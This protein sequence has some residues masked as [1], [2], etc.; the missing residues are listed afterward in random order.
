MKTILFYS[1]VSSKQLFQT[2]KFYSIDI[3]I[4]K[5]LGS[6]IILSN[7]I[8]DAFFFWKYD[9][10][11]A[12][13]Y[14]KSFFLALIAALFR[15]NTYFTGGIDDLD[16]DYASKKRYIIQ[17][18]FFRLC[19]WI[20]KSCI[21]VSEADRKNVSKILN[22]KEKLSYSEHTIDVKEFINTEILV[23]D[24][25][26][27]S[28]VWMG[29]EDNVK[30]KGIDTALKVFSLLQKTEEY[31]D[32]K[33]IIIGRKGQGTAYVESLIEKLGLKSTVILT[34]EISEAAKVAL[35]KKSKYY[36]Q[37][38]VYEGFGLAALEAIAAKNIVIHSGKGGLSNS[39]FSSGIYFNIENNL[40]AETNCLVKKMSGYDKK[41]LD[42]VVSYIDQYYDNNRRKE[43]FHRIITELTK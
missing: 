19:Y 38:S 11:F 27:T 15:K 12:Y 8:A 30:R 14:R 7:R 31:A 18:I 35:L 17:K 4:L 26:F 32:Y 28:I 40:Y 25:I 5:E 22:Q 23:K 39:I 37:L 10:V 16:A 42:R 41:Q 36:F 1:S 3:S 6:E 43:D 2:Q 20:S 21:I 29:S 34:D 33:F 9:F 13:F 24:K